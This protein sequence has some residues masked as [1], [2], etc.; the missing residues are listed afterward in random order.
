MK[1]LTFFL[2][3]LSTVCLVHCGGPKGPDTSDNDGPIK[4]D[5]QLNVKKMQDPA[6]IAAAKKHG[7]V[8]CQEGDQQ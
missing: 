1:K 4:V 6:L 2:T 5:E 8:P 7:F 3:I